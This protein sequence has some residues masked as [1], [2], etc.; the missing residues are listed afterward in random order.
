MPV[1]PHRRALPA[2]AEPTICRTPLSG[3]PAEAAVIGNIALDDVGRVRCRRA[4][5]DLTRFGN[6][7]T[8]HH[9]PSTDELN[10]RIKKA[11]T[12]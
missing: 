5:T 6:L 3:D 2:S 8:Q 9:A 11:L 10:A 7:A 1:G 4:A 12:A